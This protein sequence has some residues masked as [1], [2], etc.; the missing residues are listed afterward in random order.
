MPELEAKEAKLAGIPEDEE[1]C[2]KPS[3]CRIEVCHYNSKSP[4]ASETDG[5]FCRA[6]KILIE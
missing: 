3:T 1:D 4:P 2:K 5:L 6:T